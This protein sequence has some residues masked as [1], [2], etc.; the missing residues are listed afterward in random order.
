MCVAN[1][2]TDRYVVWCSVVQ[3]DMC[4]VV[5]GGVNKIDRAAVVARCSAAGA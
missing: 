5:W 2:D 1:V 4:G 3:C